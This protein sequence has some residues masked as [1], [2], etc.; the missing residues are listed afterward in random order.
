LLFAGLQF[1]LY[2]KGKSISVFMPYVKCLALV[3]QWYRQLWAESLGKK[4]D[5]KGNRMHAGPT[6]V[7]AIGPADQHSQIQ[8]YNEGPNDKII[9]FVEIDD[10]GVDL[11]LRLPDPW[12]DIE[13]VS[14]FAGYSL[15][16]IAH[17]E[18]QATAEALTE[19]R[20]PNGTLSIDDLSAA[21]LGGLLQT[22]M[23]ATAVM[24]ELLDVD[25][26]NQPG[27]EAGKQALYRLLGRKNQF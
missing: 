20:R 12:P 22:L 17:Y 21:S 15:S 25:A 9:T 4:M 7:A 23:A 11:R 3:G 6:P 18:R 2:R 16:D 27:V 10:F 5:R 24:G 8:L 26:F 19:N 14:Y 13:G 1:L